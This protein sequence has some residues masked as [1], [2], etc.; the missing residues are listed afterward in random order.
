MRANIASVVAG[1]MLVGTVGCQRSD[2]FDAGSTRGANPTPT[3]R[4]EAGSATSLVVDHPAVSPNV[5]TTARIHVVP[6]KPFHINSEYHFKINLTPSAGVTLAKTSFAP[7][8]AE[9]FDDGELIV[10]VAVT[11]TTTGELTVRGNIDVGVCGPKS[12][13]TE[14][15]PVAI[16]IASR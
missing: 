4:S 16:R 9:K 8:D 2:P 1:V 5:A 15:L 6:N 10:P 13:L 12:C 7:Q 14:H 11:A 3:E